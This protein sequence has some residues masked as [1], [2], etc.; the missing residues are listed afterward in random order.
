MYATDAVAQLLGLR[1]DELLEKPFYDCIQPNCL[2]EAERCL[3][4]AKANESIAYLRFWYKDP[5]VDPSDPDR[6]EVDGTE[7]EGDSRSSPAESEVDVKDPGLRDGS[8]DIDEESDP[9]SCGADDGAGDE[10]GVSSSGSR[11]SRPP[12][13]RPRR[14]QTFELE[15][16]VSCTSDGLVVVL[17]RARPPIP[18]PQPPV[19]SS[20]FNF[21]NGLFAAPWGLKPIEPYIS[22]ELLYTFRPPLLPQY[23][24]LRECVKA[25]GGP[26]LDRMYLCIPRFRHGLYSLTASHRVDAL[27][28]RRGCLRLG[29]NGHQPEPR[30]LRPRPAQDRR[31]TRRRAPGHIPAARGQRNFQRTRLRPRLLLPPLR[32]THPRLPHQTCL[33]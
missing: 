32:R 9:R 13:H 12:R 11:V 1:P 24:P 14:L 8:M 20:A 2:D 6:D 30:K 16:V 17:R 3:E 22:P 25:A 7:D 15:A 28:T 19:A 26:P 4:S 21:E 5:R 31:P 29:R 27:N 23:M 18:D 33:I 10:A